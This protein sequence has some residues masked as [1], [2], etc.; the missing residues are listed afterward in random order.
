[1]AAAS[2]T[3]PGRT[4][5]PLMTEMAHAREHHGDAALVGGGDDLVVA[6]A[7]PGLDNGRR[8]GVGDDVGAVAERK[9][10]VGGDRRAA[11]R[12]A[13]A[14]RLDGRDARAVHP[15][16]LPRADAERASRAREDDGVG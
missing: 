12:E 1:M 10:G 11:Q 6:D 4:L 7:A 3:K 16:H 9:E 15:A 14:L 5:A 13:G 8:A 2:W